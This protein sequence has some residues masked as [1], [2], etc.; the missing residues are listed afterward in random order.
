MGSTSNGRVQQKKLFGELSN[1]KEDL[2]R[3]LEVNSP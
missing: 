1:Y 3:A 2:I